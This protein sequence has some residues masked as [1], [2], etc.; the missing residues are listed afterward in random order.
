M[1]NIE[2]AHLPFYWRL[3][4]RA[5]KSDGVVGSKYPFAFDFDRELGLVIQRRDPEVLAALERIY[6]LGHNIGYLQ[7]ANELA[8]PYG[9]DFIRYLTDVL[10]AN[11]NIRRVLEV[12]CG[13]CV[14]LS[15]LKSRGYDVFGID[16]SPFAAQ[17]GA[18]KG[19]DVL[20]DFFP[21]EKL[22][23]AY[24]L[25]FHVDV[26][27]HIDDPASFLKHHYDRL[28][29]NGVIVVNVPDATE[30]IELGD[31]SMA[32]HQ[33]LNYFT[34]DSLART[35]EAAGFE[36]I[37]VDK[38]RYGGSLYAVGRRN[39]QLPALLGKW[40]T[41]AHEATYE[42]FVTKATKVMAAMNN[43]I[44]EITSDAANTLG[45]YVPLRSLPYIAITPNRKPFRFF[46]DTGHW[47]HR[48]F[49]GVDVEVENFADLKARPVSH[50]II[51]SLTF[52]DAIR[53]KI[54]AEFGETIKTLSLVEIARRIEQ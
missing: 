1:S 34:V 37:S 31:I 48:E 16:S 44:D 32:M 54:H 53:R 42:T 36:V 33:H 24:D 45:Y 35:L 2:I 5:E 21:S 50:V 19:V 43:A 9:T 51:M 13:G 52:S 15:D 8:R 17:E 14:V 11:S 23:G 3:V 40:Q 27:E 18:K 6:R 30:S 10:T 12:G 20:T 7:D 28:S 49:D 47:H 22:E 25:I 46:D 4:S 29:D 26:L 38:A 39:K 41:V